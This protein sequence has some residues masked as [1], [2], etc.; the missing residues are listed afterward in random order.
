MNY[1]FVNIFFGTKPSI[2]LI[3]KNIVNMHVE[4]N[5]TSYTRNQVPMILQGRSQGSEILYFS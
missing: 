1:I 5:A 3:F 2:E 4:M